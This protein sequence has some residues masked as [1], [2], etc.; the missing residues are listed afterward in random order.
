M[1]LKYFRD[2]NELFSSMLLYFLI[3]LS[4]ETGHEVDNRIM[5]I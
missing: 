3:S 1:P 2:I 5:E 4:G